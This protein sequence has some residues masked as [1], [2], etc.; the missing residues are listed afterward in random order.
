MEMPIVDLLSVVELDMNE[1]TPYG[2]SLVVPPARLGASHQSCHAGI[3]HCSFHDA[4]QPEHL[5]FTPFRPLPLH[6]QPFAQVG[7]GIGLIKVIDV[8][9]NRGCFKIMNSI[10]A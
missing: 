4:R 8:M 3:D 6:T 10:D 7:G 1:G 5:N 2:S 9:H